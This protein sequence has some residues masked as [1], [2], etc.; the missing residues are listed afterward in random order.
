MNF[1]RW[2]NKMSLSEKVLTSESW[3]P[4]RQMQKIDGMKDHAMVFRFS[5]LKVRMNARSGSAKVMALLL[6][7]STFRQWAVD[8]IRIH[9][10]D[11]RISIPEWES[12]ALPNFDSQFDTMFLP[13]ILDK[14]NS[15]NLNKFDRRADKSLTFSLI[16]PSLGLSS[17]AWN[18]LRLCSFYCA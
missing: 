4:A 1:G 10:C 14:N 13:F 12:C 5:L 7:L 2:I 8:P 3:N 9:F 17:T 18:L 6:W 15:A 16:P 11:P